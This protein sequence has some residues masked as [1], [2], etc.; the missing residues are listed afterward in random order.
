MMFFECEESEWMAI[1]NLK[2]LDVECFYFK[3]DGLLYI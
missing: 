3:I 2:K 1:F